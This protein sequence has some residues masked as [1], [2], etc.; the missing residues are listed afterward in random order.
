M[1]TMKEILD[2]LDRWLTENLPKTA[3]HKITIDDADRYKLKITIDLR[4]ERQM[5]RG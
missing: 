4:A 3:D 5:P 1:V 2:G